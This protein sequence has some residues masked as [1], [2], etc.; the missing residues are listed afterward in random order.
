MRSAIPREDMILVEILMILNEILAI[1]K[2]VARWH[3]PEVLL[4][5]WPLGGAAA[6]GVCWHGCY[7]SHR[8]LKQTANSFVLCSIT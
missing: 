4:V 8:R 6:E 2:G 3:I 7:P 1:S 5:G